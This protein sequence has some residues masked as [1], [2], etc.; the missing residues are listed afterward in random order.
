MRGAPA[1]HTAQGAAW[2][3]LQRGDSLASAGRRAL[4]GL[5]GWATL[6]ALV[7][8]QALPGGN[9]FALLVLFTA[10]ILAGKAVACTTIPPLL[11]MM[12]V[13]R[14]LIAPLPPP[15]SPRTHARRRPGCC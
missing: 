6:V 3:A 14:L 5:V 13:R 7:G 9:I 12:V 2:A 4:F 11:G 8:S 15:R 1:L 10:S